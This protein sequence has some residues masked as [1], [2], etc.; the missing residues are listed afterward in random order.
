M[1]SARTAYKNGTYLLY[2]FLGCFID[3]ISMMVLTL[4]VIFPAVVALGFDPVWF[5]V[6]LTIL[7]ELGL[8]T[9]PV[10]LQGISRGHPMRDIALGAT[11]FMAAML[12]VIAL[13][14]YFP[15]LATWLPGLMLK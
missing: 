7:I 6:I 15:S 13:L 5:A 4:P 11:P 2:I 9:P 8:I 1:P 12:A 14:S 3:G 10:G